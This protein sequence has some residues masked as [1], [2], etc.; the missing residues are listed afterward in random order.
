MT[1]AVVPY[2]INK[3]FNPVTFPLCENINEVYN[4]NR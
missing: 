4:F 2:K 1:H 3:N